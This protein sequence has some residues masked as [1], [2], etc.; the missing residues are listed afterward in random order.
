MGTGGIAVDDKYLG[1]DGGEFSWFCEEIAEDFEVDRIVEELLTLRYPDGP[2]FDLDWGD[3]YADAYQ[4]L[5]ERAAVGKPCAKCGA[6]LPPDLLCD[7][8]TYQEPPE[9]T[10]GER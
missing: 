7:C 6:P 1:E 3:L 10:A 2:P 8:Q 5:A 4:L 9:L